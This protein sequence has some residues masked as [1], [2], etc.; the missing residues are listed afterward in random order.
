MKIRLKLAAT[1][2]ALS[3]MTPVVAS[4]ATTPYSLQSVVNDHSMKARAEGRLDTSVPRNQI[5]IK[6]D[7]RANSDHEAYARVQTWTIPGWTTQGEI[8]DDKQTTR[9]SQVGSW[10]SKYTAATLNS[11]NTSAYGRY[12][13]KLDIPWWPDSAGN[14]VKTSSVK[15]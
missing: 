6:I 7:N 9:V 10:V 4:A 8:Q 2:L 1:V 14:W 5:R 13:V 11:A 3:M 12:L 15:Y